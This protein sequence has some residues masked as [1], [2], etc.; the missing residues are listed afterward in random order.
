MSRR[1]VMWGT[2]TGVLLGAMN[3]AVINELHGGW[4]WWVAA[5]LLTGLGAVSAGRLTAVDRLRP[6]HD[7]WSVEVEEGGVYIGQDNEGSVTTGGR[8][9]GGQRPTRGPVSRRIAPGG[10]FVGRRNT[11]TGTINTGGR[12]TP[13]SAGGR[14]GRE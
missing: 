10:V 2:G 9:A 6:A 1:Q 14:D 7:D 8:P 12:Q 4:P 13:A 5:G 3:S 11:A